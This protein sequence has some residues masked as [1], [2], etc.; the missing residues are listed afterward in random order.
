MLPIRKILCPTDFSEPSYEAIK[1]AGELAYH[2]GAEL[3]LIHVVPP[4]PVIPR[5]DGPSTFDVSLY[6]QELE[7]ASKRTL[8]EII[9]N[10]E[11]DELRG[12]LIV[13]RGN[14][15]DEIIRMAHEE[16]ADLIVIATQGCSGLDRLLFGSVAEKVVRL[17]RC[18]VLTVSDKSLE[19][20]K[21]ETLREKREEEERRE[22]TPEKRNAYV[23]RMEAELRE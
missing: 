3:C 15:A 4:V 12:R 6:E 23:D 16:N 10:L 7:M 2:F 13:L 20:A 8:A 21:K 9:N 18:P 5:G 14:A 17:A 11:W 1:I 22:E 19:E